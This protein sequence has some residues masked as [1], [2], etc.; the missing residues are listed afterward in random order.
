MQGQAQFIGQVTAG[1]ADVTVKSANVINIDLGI[2]AQIVVRDMIRRGRPFETI[3]L[4]SAGAH[5]V[6]VSWHQGLSSCSHWRVEVTPWTSGATVRAWD[7]YDG[8]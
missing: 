4:P 1:N 6:R 2:S 8:R 3:N 7:S 5:I